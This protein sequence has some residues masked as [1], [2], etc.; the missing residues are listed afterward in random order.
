MH[1][2]SLVTDMVTQAT[3]QSCMSPTGGIRPD[4]RRARGPSRFV[5]GGAAL[6]SLI[7][8]ACEN[9]STDQVTRPLALGMT[10]TTAPYYSDEELTLYQ[11][12]VP[13]PLPVRKMTQADVQAAG[14]AP[15]GTPYPRGVFLR[16][17]DESV[18]VHFTLS[19]VDG[20]DHAVWLLID[21]WNEF[22]RWQPGVTVVDDDESLPNFGYD[23]EF[24]VP[25]MQ[26]IEG[27]ITAD[28]VHEIAIKLASVETMLASPEAQ[29]PPMT[30][31][32]FDPTE[33]ANNI[34]NPQ[35]RSNSVP[36]DL[37][38]T[39]WIPPVIA[40][41]TGFDLGLRTTEPANVAV[42]ITMDVQDLRGDRFV[43][44]DSTSAEM[45]PPPQV[46]SPPGAR[47]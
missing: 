8:A 41:V 40:G 21:P 12:Q 20:A 33:T 31:S 37:I 4:R 34:F 45:G 9:G 5:T 10:S 30:G 19:N 27:T 22:V 38:Y 43:E 35:N 23:L 16:A 13:V 39:P 44:Q 42:E 46:L 15:A 17:E 14:P 11:V 36:P 3:T 29:A 47:F 6:A 24:T 32:S 1:R 25:A 28:D 18:E 26:R 2:M 7:A